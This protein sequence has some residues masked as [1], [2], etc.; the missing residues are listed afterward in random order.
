MY[1]N[2][3]PPGKRVR[4]LK[5]QFHNMCNVHKDK[6]KDNNIFVDVLPENYAKRPLNALFDKMSLA[7][8][9]SWYSLCS[10]NEQETELM[11]LENSRKLSR[12]TLQNNKVI[13]QRSKA[14]C[15]RTPYLNPLRDGDEYYYMFLFIFLPWRDEK[16]LVAPYQSA[17]QAFEK[18]YNQFDVTCTALS[19]C[20]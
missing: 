2:A 19:A 18:K 8:F 20:R 10:M 17:K 16:E 15:I 13:R 11:K 3:R 4:I 1:I 12:F 14:T 6:P 7:T 9:A 5:P